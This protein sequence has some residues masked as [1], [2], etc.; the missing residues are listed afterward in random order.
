LCVPG[1]ALRLRAR[2]RGGALF[3]QWIHGFDFSE[4]Q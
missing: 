3:Y 4:N 2:A 1:L